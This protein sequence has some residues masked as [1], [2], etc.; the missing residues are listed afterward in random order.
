MKIT[1]DGK[2]MEVEEGKTVYEVFK[3]FILEKRK[4]GVN[5]IAC[6]VNNLTEDLNY[7]LEEGDKVELLDTMT[8]DGDRVY[9]RGLLFIMARAFHRINEKA[10]LTVNYQLSD[11]MF[12]EIENAEVT[13]ELMKKI[14]DEMNRIEDADLPIKKVKM[15]KE[16][17]TEFMKKENNRVC[18]IQLES[19]KDDIVEL[20]YC[21]D[22]YNY[23]FGTMPISTG[24]VKI[25]ELRKYENGFLLIYP[26]VFAPNV[27][28]NFQE[29]K[30]L[31]LMF[32]EYRDRFKSL[33]LYTLD[34]VN[35][36]IREGRTSEL[37]L[38]SEAMQENK[39]AKIVEDIA[40]KKKRIILIAGPSSS[41]K[42]S[43]A[44][45]LSVQLKIAG[46][47]PKT[48]SVDNYFV[49]R[50]QTPLD[51]N[52]KYNFED[53]EA[54]D[55][56]LLNRDL[57]KILKGEEIEVPRFNFKI[58]TKEY[59]GDMFKLEKNEVLVMEGIHCLNDKLTPS[60]S[61]DDKYKIYISALTMLNIDY[62]N[63][64]STTDNRVIRRTV[65]D[66]RTRGYSAKDTL[67]S[68][69]S[70][71]KGEE[72]NIFPFQEQA[73]SMF[74]SSLIYEIN[75]LKPFAK[76]LYDKI[77]RSNKYYSEAQ[78]LSKFLSYFEDFSKEDLFLIPHNSLI[79]EFIG[80]SVF[81]VG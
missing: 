45:R 53:L 21:E 79:C 36:Y 58:G 22:Y 69:A 30:K 7:V 54:I 66:N 15:S 49:E 47:N 18:E 29:N 80:G 59:L 31:K 75:A 71:V 72:K 68:W 57:K 10:K 35:Q 27:N 74:N 52:G 67:E 50:D 12:C 42:T 11:A 19:T 38:F 16:Q 24:F 9:L 62:Y 78:R 40:K 46:L 76:P 51:E 23:F 63:R 56:E 13:D 5:Y 2:A 41:G 77:P 34:T 60:I 55:V 14:T 73:D 81:N 6:R 65:R 61:K 3:D 37:I 43:F 1:Y 4:E 32:D 25:F 26:A 39:I 44:N 64:I 48:I 33:G 20:Y 17:A 70:V 28:S 8:L